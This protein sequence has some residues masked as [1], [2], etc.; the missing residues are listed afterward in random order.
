MVD[1]NGYRMF[2]NKI[3]GTGSLTDA[4][5]GKN[6]RVGFWMK[7]DKAGSFQLCYDEH[8]IG[9]DEAATPPILR[10]RYKRIRLL[11]MILES[12]K[13]IRMIL[14]LRKGW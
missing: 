14:L 6:Y 9:G 7:A 4:D 12:G 13:S 8:V 3:V 2:F 11:P 10:K 1:G 5:V